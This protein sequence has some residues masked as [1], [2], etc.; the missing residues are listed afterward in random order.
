MI[1]RIRVVRDRGKTVVRS[2]EGFKF[3]IFTENYWLETE[4][5]DVVLK[6]DFGPTIKRE[7]RRKREDETFSSRKQL[8]GLHVIKKK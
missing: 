5:I 4:E 8:S 7:N 2:W 3:S 6:I 1:Q